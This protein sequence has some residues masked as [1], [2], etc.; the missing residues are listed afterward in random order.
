MFETLLE[1]AEQAFPKKTLLTI[2]EIAQFLDCEPDVV[3]NWTR[4]SDPARRPPKIIV[5]KEV[6]FPKKDFFRWLAN[7]QV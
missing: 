7:D 2:D 6:R 5:G 1:G 4:R 3:Y